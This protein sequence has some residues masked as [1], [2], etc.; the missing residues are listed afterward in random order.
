MS[1]KQSQNKNVNI[2]KLRFPEFTG[3]WE[4][5][6][7][8]ELLT[9][10]K[11]RNFDL[12]YGKDQVLS[13]SGKLGIINQIEHLGRSYAG[14]S[15]HN[16]HLVEKDNIVYTKSPLKE[17]P[18]G[19]IKLNRGNPG[20]VST[21]YAVYKVNRKTAF[22]LFLDHYFSLDANTNRYLRPLVKKGAKNDMKINNDYVLH[23]R[24]F[25][26]SVIEQ[27]KIA[28][29]LESVDS[30]IGNLKSQKES[31]E[32]YKKGIMQKIFAQEIRF[33]D[34]NGKDFPD[35]EE[36]KLGEVGEVYQPKTISQ[37]ELTDEGYNVYGANGIIGKYNRYNHE[38]EQVVVTCRGN[39]C[40]TINFTQKKAW[41]TGNAMVVNI[42]DNRNV[43]KKLL[44]Y[45]LI[46]T[47]LNY[48]ITGS[49]QPQITGDLKKHKIS[50]PSLPEQQKI[51]SFLSSLDDQIQLKTQQIEKAE[52]WKK[53]L[54]QGLFV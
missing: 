24:I 48:L 27:Q 4:H 44:Y 54:M 7:L 3:E 47:D 46:N 50:L 39:T 34:E 43:S 1:I 9:E 38:N 5:L 22:G 53:G 2:P 17:N 51:A 8:R 23:D 36:K 11:K 32:K 16:Y 6:R 41:I 12:K 20:I 25:V 45:Y 14:E 15:V 33:K 30:W 37:K 18:Y 28:S 31:L 40:G 10:S 19:I 42:D 52:K 26:P 35:W 29:F 49:G 21:L 13:V